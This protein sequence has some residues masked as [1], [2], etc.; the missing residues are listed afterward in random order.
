MKGLT[1]RGC[2]TEAKDKARNMVHAGSRKL[3]EVD[4]SFFEMFRVSR[5]GF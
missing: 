2:E 4:C 5:N 1:D 3:N